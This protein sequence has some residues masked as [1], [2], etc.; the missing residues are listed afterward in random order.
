MT[1]MNIFQSKLMDLANFQTVMAVLSSVTKIMIKDPIK[2][3]LIQYNGER[4]VIGILKGSSGELD[5]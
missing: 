4:T 2:M 3:D 5:F 1:D